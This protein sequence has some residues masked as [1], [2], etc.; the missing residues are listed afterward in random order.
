M[1]KGVY[2]QVNNE[3]WPKF[4]EFNYWGFN[5]YALQT[6]GK[7]GLIIWLSLKRIGFLRCYFVKYP[8]IQV[9]YNRL[10]EMVT[11]RW[12]ERERKNWHDLRILQERYDNLTING[13]IK[14]G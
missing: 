1:V 12:L 2:I 9:A 11:E 8:K 5:Y 10:L 13:E 3:E 7:I 14:N 6:V 4:L